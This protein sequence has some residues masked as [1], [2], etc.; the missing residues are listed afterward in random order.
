[1]WH[2]LAQNTLPQHLTERIDSFLRIELCDALKFMIVSALEDVIGIKEGCALPEGQ[3]SAMVD[4][5]QR[6]DFFF[7]KEHLQSIYEEVSLER[8]ESAFVRKI[9][10]EN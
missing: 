9:Y 6:Y 1:M 4:D 10:R 8:G 3:V 2:E 5:V 7:E